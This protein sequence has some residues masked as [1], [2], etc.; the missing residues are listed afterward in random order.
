MKRP[1]PEAGRPPVASHELGTE[2]TSELFGRFAVFAVVNHYREPVY[3]Y[4]D[5]FLRIHRPILVV[6]P[7]PSENS[8]EEKGKLGGGRKEFS[9]FIV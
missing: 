8:T 4:R 2:K 6:L 3:V 5:F 9:T 1:Q 7:L